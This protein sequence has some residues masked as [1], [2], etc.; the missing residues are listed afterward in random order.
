MLVFSNACS[1]NLPQ[2]QTTLSPEQRVDL[3]QAIAY[4][5]ATFV[6]NTGMQLITAFETH[7]LTENE[8]FTE[9]EFIRNLTRSIY[10]KNIIL[11]KHY[12]NQILDNEVRQSISSLYVREVLTMIR[13]CQ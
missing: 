1:S 9:A 10:D 12:L 5:A 4:D 11:I 2:T 13:F 6:R 3:C 7:H 8:L